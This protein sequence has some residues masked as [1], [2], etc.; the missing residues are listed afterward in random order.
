MADTV[1]TMSMKV[2]KTMTNMRVKKSIMMS[3]KVKKVM[4]LMKAREFS[5]LLIPKKLISKVL[6]LLMQAL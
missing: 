4:T 3:T 5:Q 6:M 2:K 1:V